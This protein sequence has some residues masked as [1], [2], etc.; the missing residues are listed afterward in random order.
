MPG[1]AP[2]PNPVPHPAPNPE[3]AP[4]SPA[5]G[6]LLPLGIS[7]TPYGSDW[8]DTPPQLLSTTEIA[9]TPWLAGCGIADLGLI[10]SPGTTVRM[11][12]RVRVEADGTIS[13]TYVDA[14]S[15]NPALD[16]LVSCIG[17]RHLRLTPATVGGQPTITDAYQIEVQMQF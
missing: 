17:Q 10:A 3:L 4:P 6:Q 13:A 8:P 12:I 11:Q 16:N 14:S 15:G 7:A 2:A 1:V 5:G 9:M